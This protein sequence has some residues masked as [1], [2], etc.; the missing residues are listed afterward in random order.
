MQ[1]DEKEEEDILQ[2][3]EVGKVNRA[4]SEGRD[5]GY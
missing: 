3:E 2:K 1:R 4:G 5:G